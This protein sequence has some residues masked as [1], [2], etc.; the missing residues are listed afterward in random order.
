[1]FKKFLRVFIP[2]FLVSLFILPAV[3]VGAIKNGSFDGTNHPYVCL[4]VFYDAQD[5]PLWRTTGELISSTKVLTAGH[6]TDGTSGARVWFL[7]TIPANSPTGYPYGGPNSYHGTPYTNPDYRSVPNPGLPG[8]DYHDVGVVI[9]DSPIPASVV[10]SYAALPAAGQSKTIRNMSL[11]DLVGYGVT[12]QVR[13]GGVSP[14]DSWVWNRQR[15]FA[16]AN[17][18]QSK[19]ALASEFLKLSANPALEKGSTTFGDSGGPILKAG[20]NIIL[21]INAFVTNSNC[22]GV[23]YAQR[24]DIQDILDWIADPIP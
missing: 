22:T 6:G 4:V 19:D 21:G 1:M 17:L 5:K 8:F 10:S 14:Q 2:L 12:S 3:P 18:I 23:T 24:I 11:V 9:L 7:S 20:T 13:G 15:N 16:Q